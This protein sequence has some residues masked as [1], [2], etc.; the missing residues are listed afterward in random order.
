ME[1]TKDFES[2]DGRKPS[3][4]KLR[5]F[6]KFSRLD[7]DELTELLDKASRI[8]RI[9]L[10]C[11][12]PFFI[13]I[14]VLQI[15]PEKTLKTLP[16]D[17]EMFSDIKIDPTG[18]VSL[19]AL[20]SRDSSISVLYSD[21]KFDDWI[22]V[23]LEI[24]SKLKSLANNPENQELLEI[25]ATSTGFT[26]SYLENKESSWDSLVS[27]SVFEGEY[28]DYNFEYD[29]GNQIGSIS[30]PDEEIV[31]FFSIKKELIK[32]Q[33][34]NRKPDPNI[35]KLYKSDIYTDYTFPSSNYN[36]FPGI[37][38][39]YVMVDDFLLEEVRILNLVAKEASQFNVDHFKYINK[40]EDISLKNWTG[41]AMYISDNSVVYRI[42]F[43]Q[44]EFSSLNDL[45]STGVLVSEF[46]DVFVEE[47]DNGQIILSGGPSTLHISQDYGKSWDEKNIS[48]DS[49]YISEMKFDWDSGNGI[50]LA[51]NGIDRIFKTTD[52]GSSWME[53]YAYRAGENSL[54]PLIKVALL[55]VILCALIFLF[56]LFLRRRMLFKELKKDRFINNEKTPL[57]LISDNPSDT[58]TIGIFKSSVNALIKLIKNE[59]T[60]PPVSI[61]INGSW[62]SGKSSLMSMIKK[63]LEQDNEEGKGKYLT[64][65]FNVWHFES[66]KNLLTVFLTTMMSKCE[67][68]FGLSFRIR[69]FLNKVRRLGFSAKFRFFFSIF[70]LAPIILFLVLS[71]IPF[72]DG[73]STTSIPF[74]GSLFTAIPIL[75]NG[76]FSE[77]IVS[78]LLISS[79]AVMWI[80]GILFLRK[81]WVPSGISS[82]FNIFPV[83]QLKMDALNEDPGFREKYKKEFWQVLE[84]ADPDTKIVI[85]IDDMDRVTGTKIKQLLEGINFIADTASKPSE[86]RL[87]NG[88]TYFFIGMAMDEVIKNL[89]AALIDKDSNQAPAMVDNDSKSGTLGLRFIEKMIDLTVQIPSLEDADKNG[90]QSLYKRDH[91]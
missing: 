30:T 63:Q 9:V 5:I 18:K 44:E 6:G 15:L 53:I 72:P 57:A 23:K 26:L 51:S 68:Y 40:E 7:E 37:R 13:T 50:V 20:N 27:Y 28:R 34:Q 65:W 80:M 25:R 60:S 11:L 69:L 62:G 3:N 85:F 36:V 91:E 17:R 19:L 12:I 87:S 77:G 39:G 58:D 66:E 21:F 76:V 33:S 49:L 8:I 82:F 29:W 67:G 10:Y 56:V 47:S 81:E 55:L 24:E 83:E 78:S 52:F 89:E 88:N 16:P 54:I 1:T 74:L 38:N 31:I 59:D 32:L 90:M 61:A 73:I 46:Q 79:S 70:I 14:G 43:S 41:Y 35:F 86:V 2:K 22:E 48:T 4:P 64:I 75:I 84:A 42:P 45:N 71:L